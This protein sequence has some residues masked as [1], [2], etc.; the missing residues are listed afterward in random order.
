MNADR[1][2]ISAVIVCHNYARYLIP[3]LE[4]LL[5]QTRPFDEIILVDDASTDETVRV[6]ARYSS[7]I[8]LISTSCR[9][10]AKAR[11][12]GV[13][14]ATG[15]FLVMVDADN[16]LLPAFNE[17]LLPPLLANPAA[18]VSYSRWFLI[19][20]DAPDIRIKPSRKIRHSRRLLQ[21]FNYIDN[22][23]MIRRE[24]WLGQ[25]SKLDIFL[26]W[27]HWLRV[28]RAGW[29]FLT[30][31]EPLFYYRVHPE[32]LSRRFSE[33]ARRSLM[34][35]SRRKFYPYDSAVLTVNS[36]SG[37]EEHALKER[38]EKLHCEGVQQAVVM[39]I[40]GDRD[41]VRAFR[42]AGF[43]VLPFPGGSWDA[44]LR[45]RNL[46][47][48]SWGWWQLIRAL[49]FSRNFTR[50]RRV[51]MLHEAA[52]IP[53]DGFQRLTRVMEASRCH[54][55][56]ASWPNEAW[57]PDA[58]IRKPK[59]LELE[60][61]KIRGVKPRRVFAASI[62]CVLMDSVFFEGMPWI[63]AG[64]DQKYDRIEWNT[65]EWAENQGY[66]WM[67]DPGTQVTHDAAETFIV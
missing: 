22:C 25:D 33:G 2:R 21:N 45:I 28:D 53:A 67:V 4:S 56:S 55:V 65:G 24:A 64:T 54:A 46:E 37:G 50:A 7:D 38:L 34:A 12:C 59:N 52:E 3:C 5:R 51:L 58:W 44:V 27:E 19:H 13:E 60:P 35:F 9:H 18:G 48:S 66:V 49:S 14:A 17:K 23:A 39:D 26:D 36:K 63:G 8:R 57:Q 15:D 29:Q 30:V 6:A 62:G 47:V 40:S 1:V 31:P 20:E 42:Q 11:Q 43:T 41:A 32:S 10:P 16:W 61:V